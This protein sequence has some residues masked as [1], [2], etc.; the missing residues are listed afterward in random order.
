MKSKKKRRIK[1]KEEEESERREDEEE[2]EQVVAKKDEEKDTAEEVDAWC[3]L[4]TRDEWNVRMYPAH[5][6][7]GF[8]SNGDEPDRAPEESSTRV[9]MS[10]HARK[11]HAKDG[12]RKCTE[13]EV[14]TAPSMEDFPGVN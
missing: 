9:W 11:L 7:R 6:P 5:L 14:C 4:R 3:C 12:V 10:L 1:R 13:R 8:V 2:R